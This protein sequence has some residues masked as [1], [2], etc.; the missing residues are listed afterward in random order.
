MK[1]GG[2]PGFADFRDQVIDNFN[3]GGVFWVYAGHGRVEELDRVPSTPS[4][5]PILD[6]DS[7]HRLVRPSARA[8]IALMLACFAGAYD[9]RPDCIAER[10]IHEPGGPIAVVAGSRVTLPYG[11]ATLATSMID[12]WY[13]STPKTLGACWQLTLQSIRDRDP[14]NSASMLDAMAAMMSPT[15]KQLPQERIEHTHL[16]NLLGDPLL[17]L[18]HPVPLE[19]SSPVSGQPG[20]AVTVSG[21]SPIGGTLHVEIHR[22]GEH[23]P[24][25]VNKLSPA[26]RYDQAIRTRLSK[27][28]KEIEPGPFQVSV[29]LPA[30]GHRSIRI[31]VRIEGDTE[32]AL[33]HDR[34]LIDTPRPKTKRSIAIDPA[35]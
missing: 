21:T 8:P 1:V 17:R 26:E 35:P 2:V 20:E 18:R 29:S 9:A 6:F 5:K 11:N 32:F 16:Y 23:R 22:I 7:T 28:A 33:G 15:A 14:A 24:S 19:L 12:A 13:K 31:V 27:S 25:G 10:M 30:E 34:I 3:S 4:G